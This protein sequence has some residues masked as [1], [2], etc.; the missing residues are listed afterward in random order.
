MSDPVKM[1]M[2][3]DLKDAGTDAPFVVLVATYGGK[4]WYS[5][6]LKVEQADGLADAIKASCKRARR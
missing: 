5:V 2:R 4:D 1:N 3:V 6:T